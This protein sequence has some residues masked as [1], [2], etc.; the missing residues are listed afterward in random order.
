MSVFTDEQIKEI[1]AIFTQNLGHRQYI[2]AR[3]VPIFGRKDEESIE[4]DN[5]APY[6]P[7]TVVLHQGNSYTSRQFV[8]TGIDILNQD[9]W[10]NT[11]NFNAQLEQY[12]QEV[13]AFDQRIKDNAQAIVDEGI[14]RANADT[15]LQDQITE[16]HNSSMYVTPEDFNYTGGD[17]KPV[18]EA[19]D[20]Q[21]QTWASSKQPIKTLLLR[22]AFPC[23]GAI[24]KSNG[25]KISGGELCGW[26]VVAQGCNLYPMNPGQEYILH[27]GN[28]KATN[29]GSGANISQ[30]VSL[31]NVTFTTYDYSSGL[32][33]A[34][35]DYSKHIPV[36]NGLI[37]NRVMASVYT[38]VRFIFFAGRAFKMSGSY[39]NTFNTMFVRNVINP[40]GE[41]I[42]FDTIPFEPSVESSNVSA[43]LF[44][45]LQ[46]ESIICKNII[47]FAVNAIFANNVISAWIHEE[48]ASE[49]TNLPVTQNQDYTNPAEKTYYIFMDEN[50][51]SEVNVTNM[52]V[53]NFAA[54]TFIY[55]TLLYRRQYFAKMAASGRS[56]VNIGQFAVQ[57]YGASSV[58]L[59]LATATGTN[60]ER[61]FMFPNT[62]GLPGVRILYD[63]TNAGGVW[64]T[65]NDKVLFKGL[66]QSRQ[67]VKNVTEAI[68]YNAP[69]C[70]TYA[71][72]QQG[73]VNG[74][75]ADI[76]TV[77]SD[78]VV[79]VPPLGAIR[80]HRPNNTVTFS[81]VSQSGT[82]VP[83]TISAT[84][85]YV[86]IQNETVDQFYYLMA[87]AEGCVA[88]SYY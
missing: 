8:P 7:L 77:A 71:D 19:Y 22:G 46:T 80:V 2:G 9:F 37:I 78:A 10:A 53:N 21:V 57:G 11:G 59:Y 31:E 16:I 28:Y 66:Q 82:V 18:I 67:L 51:R 76:A 41:A 54:F 83:I 47:R 3:Y 85:T 72:V 17:I 23:S 24:M 64:P 49:M 35:S 87:S 60:N 13:L 61:Y 34:E 50:C 5:T 65:V 81:F 26:R 79:V 38:N 88:L 6:E 29:I 84:S 63:L 25:A 56:T 55:D 62:T 27:L 75:G 52:T 68:P 42:L 86:T 12:R 39:E 1:L 32:A 74:V 58:S 40:D 48:N 20:A 69:I 30:N 4:W 33:Y 43:N 15:A 70:N 14:N 36:Q 45:C 44:T 73:I